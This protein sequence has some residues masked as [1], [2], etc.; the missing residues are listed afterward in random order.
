MAEPF[1]A[2]GAWTTA[3]KQRL[4]SGTEMDVEISPNSGAIE[5]RGSGGRSNLQLLWINPHARQGR[6]GLMDELVSTSFCLHSCRMTARYEMRQL[7]SS[8]LFF[9][10]LL[11]RLAL[12]LEERGTRGSYSNGSVLSAGSEGGHQVQRSRSR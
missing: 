11:P 4:W 8:F 9:R 10:Q 7:V 2:G 6:S 5:E 3:D 1:Y 12:K